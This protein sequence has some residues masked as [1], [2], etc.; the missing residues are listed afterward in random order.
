MTWEQKEN[1]ATSGSVTLRVENSISIPP[2]S[3]IKKEYNF[4]EIYRKD[5]DFQLER[6][7]IINLSLNVEEKIDEIITKILIKKDSEISH[8]FI[9]DVLTREFFTFMAK[10]NVLKSLLN[11]LSPFNRNDY[12][13]LLTNIKEIIK[14]RNIFAHGKNTYLDGEKIVIDYFENGNKRIEITSEFLDK[15]NEKIR[16]IFLKLNEISDILNNKN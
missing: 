8:L 7:K 3:T 14:I 1:M 9:S 4:D 2:N 5:L 15:F 10:W 16:L 6:G 12:S 13:E 11:N